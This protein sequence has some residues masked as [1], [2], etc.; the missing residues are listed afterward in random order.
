VREHD[1]EDDEE[2]E[3]IDMKECGT[4]FRLYTGTETPNPKPQTL[5]PV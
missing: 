5:N 1:G 4:D 2:G 3:R